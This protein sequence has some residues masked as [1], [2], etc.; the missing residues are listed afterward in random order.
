S[1]KITGA[2]TGPALCTDLCFRKLQKL[3]SGY[4]DLVAG[5]LVFKDLVKGGFL[6]YLDVNEENDSNI[7][8]YEAD[9]GP[10]TTHLEIE[11]FTL[12]GVCAGLIP[13]PHHNQ[14]PR[15]TYQCAMGKQAMG[16]I[17]LNQKN[18]I[19]TLMYNLV[20]PMRPMVKSRTIELILYQDLPAG[21]NAIVA[22]MSYSGYDIEDAIILNNAS[23][24]RGYGRCLVYRNQKC[25]LKR[26]ANQTSDRVL[27]PLVDAE[28]KKPIFRHESLDQD[29]ICATGSRMFNKQVLINKC[30]PTVTRD[31]LTEPGLVR[32][33]QPAEFRETPITYKGPIPSYIEKVMLT[34]DGNDAT[35]IKILLRQTRRPELG[36]KFSSRHGQKG[37]TGLIVQQEDMPF[38]DQGICPDMIMN[39][40]G[41]PSRMTVGKLME[42]LGGKAGVLKGKFHYGTAFGGSKVKDISEELIEA[43][44]NYQGKD[45]LTSGITGESLQAYI[46]HGPVYYQKLKHMVIDKM[47]GRS[48]GPRAVLT[49][50][51]TEGRSSMLLVER[52]MISS[53]AF[54]VE[55]C[56]GCGLLA[57]S[58][59][60]H[61]CQTSSGV[62]AI[63]IPYACKLLF[64]ELQS[65]NIVPR[66]KLEKYCQ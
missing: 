22:V 38:N 57:Y 34:C 26:Y 18:R 60:C 14:S 21:Q 63:R 28:T 55:V 9:I 27:G 25:A 46:Y 53:D 54:N 1:S 43:G 66:L 39:P 10:S 13:Y 52:L 17:A 7:A 3:R 42:L 19:D 31:P 41:F 40:H 65:M 29:G 45:T 61:S 20:Y 33:N 30:M 24:D 36:D 8:L 35:L 44:Y 11:P 23:L 4:K 16:T 58:G 15:N 37:V 51:P 62:S 49:R 5:N 56:G 6:E 64:Q 12:L 59:W 47:H 50:Q 32:P 2:Q 48:T